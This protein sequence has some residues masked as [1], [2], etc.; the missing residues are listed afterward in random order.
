MPGGGGASGSETQAAARVSWRGRL[1]RAPTAPPQRERPKQTGR[2]GAS[3]TPDDS[4]C[5]GGC[6]AHGEGGS[7]GVAVGA[8]ALWP[9]SEALPAA[10]TRTRRGATTRDAAP[11]PS[12]GTAAG[13][14]AHFWAVAPKQRPPRVVG[15]DARMVATSRACAAVLLRGV[16]SATWRAMRSG[17]PPPA[18]WGRTTRTRSASTRTSMTR[19]SHCAA[20]VLGP[21]RLTRHPHNTGRR[22]SGDTTA[23]TTTP[24]AATPAP[25]ATASSA[26]VPR[27]R[28]WCARLP[29]VVCTGTHGGVSD[30][31]PRQQAKKLTQRAAKAGGSIA[32]YTNDSNPFGDPNL[33]QRCAQLALTAPRL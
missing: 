4:G 20:G 33:T 1:V 11:G 16:R 28:S 31:A 2:R 29:G 32:G 9:L 30:S 18:L 24:A 10:T 7:S 21:Q 17:L 27:R 5:R 22:R 26:S 25:A 12:S 14:T 6:T 19:A 13:R 8:P 3:H 23:Q 15:S